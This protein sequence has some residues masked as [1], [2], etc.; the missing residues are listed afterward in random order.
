MGKK[1]F[2]TWILVLLFL[3]PTGIYASPG[4]SG[5]SVSNGIYYAPVVI[6]NGNL[7]ATAWAASVYRN[8]IREM[9]S[10]QEN[11]DGY[12]LS[13]YIGSFDSL[14]LIQIVKQEYSNDL[15]KD[16]QSV[17]NNLP[18]GDY[19]IPENWSLPRNYTVSSDA[20]Y[21]YYT[22]N[23]VKKE[24][25]KTS[26]NSGKITVHINSLDTPLIVRT[27]SAKSGKVANQILKIDSESAFSWD[28]WSENTAMESVWMGWTTGLEAGTTIADLS[29]R[30]GKA[31]SGTMIFDLGFQNTKINVRKTEDGRI[32]VAIPCINVEGDK[33]IEKIEIANSRENISSDDEKLKDKH[34]L[35][36]YWA[37]YEDAAVEDGTLTLIYDSLEDAALGKMVRVSTSK[38]ILTVGEIESKRQYVYA[39]V[40]IKPFVKHNYVTN[41]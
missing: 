15:L 22:G 29:T 39:S 17:G 31:T 27:W 24:S 20:N 7:S 2:I 36:D 38:S 23:E 21:Y 6:Y 9:V 4:M 25:Y 10:Y 28:D 33:H 26:M 11:G 40:Y 37:N 32:K 34:T 16:G 41:L 1:K 19:N 8:Q 35:S 13:F 3:I 18:L 5:R 14:D 30:T 12:D